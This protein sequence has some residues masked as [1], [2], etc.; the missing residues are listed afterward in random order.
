M[1][2]TS[3]Q[4]PS[5]LHTISTLQVCGWITDDRTGR[6]CFTATPGS[7]GHLLRAS[8][9]PPSGPHPR[10]QHGPSGGPEAAGPPECG[11]QVSRAGYGQV[12]APPQHATQGPSSG[13][14]V[15]WQ[16]ELRNT[17]FLILLLIRPFISLKFT[18]S[19]HFTVLLCV[20]CGYFDEWF[21][22]LKFTKHT[23]VQP[24]SANQTEQIVDQSRTAIGG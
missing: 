14:E 17:W 3:S 8:Q 22:S 9:P 1:R 20:Q 6:R 10:L 4:Y 12:P 23:V 24:Q 11:R 16:W 2:I 5:T 18:N 21:G 7:P 19:L 15:T 13:S